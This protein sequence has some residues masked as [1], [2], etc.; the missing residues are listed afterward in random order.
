MEREVKIITT[1][2]G[3]HSLYLPD[4]NE[5]YHSS[6]GALTESQHV[7]IEAG[8]VHFVATHGREPVSILEIG[9]GT[10][11]NAW[12][13]QTYADQKEV[14]VH[15]TSLEPFPLTE[16]VYTALNYAE[17]ADR[18]DFLAL[19]QAP[20]GQ[21]MEMSSWFTLEKVA[22]KLQHFSPEKHF[23]LVFFDAFAPSKQADMWE[24]D[25][26]AKTVGYMAPRSVLVT[27]CAK[28]Q[29]KRDLTSLGLTVE[30]LAGPP[31]KKEM[32]R[33]TT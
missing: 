22:Q 8:L 20:W 28:G 29:F 16:P 10:G 18:A 4:L 19:H 13:S 21:A 17:E 26:L 9:F 30:S 33:A 32:V 11:L 24:L 27:Y 1:E 31:G 14:Q 15:Y 2:D 23:D 3:S 12:L 6:H 5:T 7:F 25:L